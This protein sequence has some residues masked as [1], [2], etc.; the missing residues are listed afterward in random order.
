VLTLRDGKQR[1]A[2]KSFALAPGKTGSVKLKLSAAERRKLRKRHTLKLAI[3]ISAHDGAGTR[4]K[5]KTVRVTL[6][7]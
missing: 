2:Q 3:A 6:K 1:V 7:R 5:A 4:A